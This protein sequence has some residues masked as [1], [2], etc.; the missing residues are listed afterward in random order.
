MKSVMNKCVWII[1]WMTLAGKEASTQREVSPSVTS[2]HQSWTCD[3]LRPN[4]D[5]RGLA[6]NHLRAP[7]RRV[8]MKTGDE[9]GFWSKAL[10]S[11]EILQN[12][13]ICRIWGSPYRCVCERYGHT[14]TGSLFSFA[15]NNNQTAMYPLI[16][17]TNAHFVHEHIFV[18]CSYMFRRQLSHL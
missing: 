18:C 14:Q 7:V 8:C 2:T 16:T 12:E 15:Q 9:D 3:G 4:T 5:F 10:L 6:T 11:N 17:T 13:I 1:G